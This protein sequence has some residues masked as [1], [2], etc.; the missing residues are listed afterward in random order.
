MKEQVASQTDNNSPACLNAT[1]AQC[2]MVH[3][4]CSVLCYWGGA[5]RG[6]SDTSVP[7]KFVSCSRETYK[8]KCSL[9]VQVGDMGAL[10]RMFQEHRAAVVE[11]RTQRDTMKGSLATVKEN[12]ARAQR[13]AAH[14]SRLRSVPLLFL[15]KNASQPAAPNL[16]CSL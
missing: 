7:S 2:Y 9:G 10:Q 11:A 8:S 6:R 12:V 15:L 16:C 4:S 13:C 1:C 5:V 3:G 14:S